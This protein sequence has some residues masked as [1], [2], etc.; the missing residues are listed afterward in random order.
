MPNA[1]L[2]SHA[3]LP[4][5]PLPEAASQAARISIM[6]RD[7]P[8]EAILDEYSF[9]TRSK[10]Y[11][12]KINALAFAHPVHRNPAE[13]ASF[14]VYNAVNG[15]SD[16]VLVSL[17]AESSAPF[18]LL[19]RDSQFSFWASAIHNDQV[20]AIL[21]QANIS[22]DQLGNVLS[23]YA[24]DLQPQRLIEV[25]QGRDTFRHQAFRD[26]QPLQL[27]LW[28][29]DVTSP[30][31]VK[32]F[33]HTVN[34]LRYYTKPYDI[35]ENDVTKLAIQLLGATILAD[36]GVLGTQIRLE[37]AL[38][39]QLLQQA[40]TDFPRYFEPDL[41]AKYYQPA[42][43][44]YKVLRQVR[45][46]GFVPDML[47]SIYTAAYSKEERK[48][49]GR[50]DTP[51]YL[52][53]RIWENIPVE[54]LPPHQRVVAD[55]TCGWGSFL[56]AGH[57]RLST[58]TD[59][60][61]SRLRAQLHGNDIDP[62]TAQLA[63]LGLLLSTSE[64]SWNIDS[65]NALEWDWL[66]QH[67]PNIIVGNPPFGAD[68]KRTLIDK[69]SSTERKRY[70]KANKFLEYAIERLAQNG[71]LA[72]VMPSSFTGAEASPQYRK[73]LL[74]KCDVLELWELPIGVFDATAQT[75]VVFAQ[76]RAEHHANPVRTRTVQPDLLKFFKKSGPFTASGLVVDQ[77]VWNEEARKSKHS[78]NTHIMD[79]RIIL[80]E[81]TW[82]TIA[83]YCN[84][85]EKYAE[86][87]RGAIKGKKSENNKWKDYPFPKKV[88]WLTGVKDVIKRPF[89]IDYEKAVTITYPN[90][91]ERPRI[92]KESVL[93]G[94]KILVAYD[95][96]PSWGRRVKLAIERK[97]YYVSDSFWVIAPKSDTQH[98][99]C[100]V[101]AA[102]L[103]WDVSNA[104]IVEHLKNPAIP[105]RA[106]STLPMPSDLSENDCKALT[107]AVLKLED[108]VKANQSDSQDVKDANQT[109]DS[110]LKVAY[111]LDDATFERLRKVMEWDNKPQITLD[112]MLDQTEANWLISGIV[113]SIDAEEGTITLWME[114]FDELQ[115]VQIIPSMPGW[116][117]RSE[118]TFRTKI[119]RQYVK[120]GHINYNTDDWGAFRP[121]PY[122]YMEEEELLDEFAK[123]MQEDSGNRVR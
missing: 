87:I 118:A 56:I 63:G 35:T 77:S 29:A 99:S 88:L 17:L 115:S 76:K 105:E 119:P 94:R 117:L 16:A 36:T 66:K 1:G 73:Q 65:S 7:F 91:L 21:V 64:D 92:D 20:E 79:Y 75:V 86:V 67:Q 34:I 111:H 112:T 27:S 93:A 15:Q 71:Y 11:F 12:I 49:L 89:F 33:S 28:A 60:R 85:L 70:E 38:L 23:D 51:L 26:I 90:D 30:L 40:H 113:D 104:W 122:A 10:E 53:R 107:D 74:E 8:Q 110:I 41:F 45:Y 14:T 52:T 39:S 123:L 22:Y 4:Y 19:H 2:F 82:Q 102:V 109:I 18:H 68:R 61:P 57:E 101:L 96:N 81:S 69:N 72:L 31:L 42:E 100:E 114:G 46:A 62:F 80:P 84:N 32:H 55:M 3:D 58:L 43:Q 103:N 44:A 6:K 121:Q 9:S 54:Y 50:F 37:G 13:Y 78:E 5:Q 120:Q 116:M 59:T 24:I 106:I 95:P 47:T 48:N 98:L 83:S 97:N 25:K 108:A